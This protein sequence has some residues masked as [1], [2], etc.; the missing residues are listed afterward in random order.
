[1]ATPPTEAAITIMTVMPMLLPL[2]VETA[3]ERDELAVAEPAEAVRV[4]VT[5]EPDMTVV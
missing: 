2:V 1:M 5:C 3:S 4:S